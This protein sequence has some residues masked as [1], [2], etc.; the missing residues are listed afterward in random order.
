MQKLIPLFERLLSLLV[1]FLL[2]SGTVV[3]SGKYLG[4]TFAGT[5]QKT[6]V[7][8]CVAQPTTEQLAT[9]GLTAAQ[10]TIADSASWLVMGTDGKA[11][12]T[13]IATEPYARDVSGFA[14]TT[15][16]YI[17]IGVEGTVRGIASADNSESPDFYRRATEGVFAQMVGK[18]TA[19]VAA[20]KV[21][22]VSGATYSSNALINNVKYTLAARSQSVGTAKGAAPAIGWG[23]TVCI[24]V[25]LVLGFVVAI[26]YR[27]R[28]WLRLL[29][30]ALNVVVTGFWCGQFLSLSLVRGWIENGLDP[31]LYLPSLLLLLVAIVAPYAGRSHHYCQW[32]C[33]YGSLQELAWHVPVKKWQLGNRAY[34]LMRLV[35]YVV[36]SL[37]LALMWFGVGTFLLDYEPFSAFLVGTATPAVIVLAAAFVVLGIF[38]P[39]PWCRCLCP[40]GTLLELAEDKGRKKS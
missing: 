13:L 34:R 29:T 22:A 33:P 4:R 35:R 36:L 10:L 19:D 2:L 23:R 7:E 25:V 16:L 11:A 32:V 38:V 18:S 9:L 12:G 21:D 8:T 27:G 31:V 30:L 39:R 20:S 14:G 26:K 1:V 40:V 37:L 17:Y 24:A 6:T 28:K 3:W 5:A 15:P